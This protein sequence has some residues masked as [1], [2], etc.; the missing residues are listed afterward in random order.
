MLRGVDELKEHSYKQ[1][2]QA[3]LVKF[4]QVIKIR[5]AL[6]YTAAPT[7]AA[8]DQATNLVTPGA[9]ATLPQH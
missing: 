4:N 2:V 9:D 7:K 3:M 8:G 5:G 1:A 6:K